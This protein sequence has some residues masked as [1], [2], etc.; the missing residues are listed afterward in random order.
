MKRPVLGRGL[1][2]LLPRGK[3]TATNQPKNDN[4]N[5]DS[6]YVVISV[7]SIVPN[8]YQ[9]RKDFPEESLRELSE[10]IR[11][12]GLIQPIVVKPVDGG[13]YQLIAGERRWQATRLAGLPT[14]RAIVDR[15][16]DGLDHLVAALLENLQREDL[17][18]LDE[19]EAFAKLSRD[20]ALSH[21]EIARRMGRSRAAVSN[22]LRL[23]NL[24]DEVQAA[25][26]TRAVTV[27]QVRPLL[28]LDA[29]AALALFREIREHNLSSRDAE[30]RA[31]EAS[32]KTSSPRRRRA[33][34]PGSSDIA[35]A[36]AEDRLMKTWGRAVRIMGKG[37]KG[38]VRIDFY[39]QADL[40]ELVDRLLVPR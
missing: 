20:F 38:Y 36:D 25:V 10:S 21:E 39:S 30:A 31:G 7:D 12:E 40:I 16:P 28:S 26:R 19:A 14:I 32:G 8:P 4:N 23:L 17:N 5:T 1:D 15:K 18:P 37:P 24:P 11:V 27:G 9:P 33:N 6:D 22:A 2:T 34:A 35:R 3:L 29:P 13:R